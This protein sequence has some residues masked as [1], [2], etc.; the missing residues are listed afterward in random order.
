[1]FFSGASFWRCSQNVSN[2]I[3]LKD[4]WRNQ[5]HASLGEPAEDSRRKIPIFRRGVSEPG[6][7]SDVCRWFCNIKKQPVIPDVFLLWEGEVIMRA[8]CTAL[9]KAE[10]KSG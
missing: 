10:R 9:L 8:A 1:M 7:A 6:A 4:E 2:V 3:V 5:W